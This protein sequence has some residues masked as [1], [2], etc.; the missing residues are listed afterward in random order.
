M[1]LTTATKNSML[2][3]LASLITH[4]G[5][6]N[7]GTELSSGG[8]YARQAIAWSAAAAGVLAM[9]GTETFD[10][11][12]GSTVNQVIF[13][14]SATIGAGTDRGNAPVTEEVFGGQGTYELTSL[15]VTLNDA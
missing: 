6:A 1:A 11:D 14:D 10:V 2:D 3:H 7:A 13:R 12:A 15:T 8:V 4:I 5:L 9:T